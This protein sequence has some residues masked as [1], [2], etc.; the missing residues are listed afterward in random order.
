MATI[1]PMNFIEITDSY[2]RQVPRIAGTCIRISEVALMHL[3][4][5]SIDWMAKNFEV[6]D[7]AKIHAALAYYYA[8][9]AEIN[10]EIAEADAFLE[11]NPCVLNSDDHMA[12]IKARAKKRNLD[13]DTL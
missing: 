3:T 6:L 7:Y 2:G 12:M 13:A 11:N 4:N 5:T 1:A 10:E 8:H 9:Q